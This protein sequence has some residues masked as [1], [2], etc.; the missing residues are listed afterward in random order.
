MRNVV[1]DVLGEDIARRCKDIWGLDEEGELKGIC[2]DIGVPGLWYNTGL[3][4]PLS[5]YLNMRLTHRG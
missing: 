3:A 5:Q 2:R 1:S 4:S